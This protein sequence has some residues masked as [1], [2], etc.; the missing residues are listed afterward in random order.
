[1]TGNFNIRDSLWDPSFPHHSSISDNLIII[2][3]SFNL[4]LLLL[5]NSIFT[6]YSDTESEL[7]L[8]IDLIFF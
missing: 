8:V 4:E 6:R 1:M 3:D 7:N 2:A 5:T